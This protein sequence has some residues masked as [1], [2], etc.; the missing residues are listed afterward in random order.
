MFKFLK[1]KTPVPGKEIL[2]V[3]LP[4]MLA[5]E[6]KIDVL[7]PTWVFIQSWAREELTRTRELNDYQKVTE[8]KTAALRGRIKLL[9]EILK[10]PEDTQK[11]RIQDDQEE[12]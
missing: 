12:F 4:D 8:L 6:G 5:T 3:K 2:E 11:G 10:L 9:K 1:K 7:S